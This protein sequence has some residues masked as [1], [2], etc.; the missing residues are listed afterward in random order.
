LKDRD[1]WTIQEQ[2]EDI[3][4]DDIEEGPKHVLKS[5]HR[6]SMIKHYSKDTLFTPSK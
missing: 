4:E 3:D 1:V 2:E 5:A 6:C